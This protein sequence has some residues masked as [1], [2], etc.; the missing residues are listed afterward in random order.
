MNIILQN[1]F[2]NDAKMYLY[3]QQNSY[4]FKLLDRGFITYKQFTNNMKEKYKER[5]TDK[6]GSVIDNINLVSSVIDVLN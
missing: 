3:L 1:S 6:L 2:K 4:Y 5:I